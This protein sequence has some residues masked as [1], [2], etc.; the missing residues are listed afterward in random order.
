[1][2]PTFALFFSMAAAAQKPVQ[3]AKPAAHPSDQKTI[4]HPRLE[5]DPV[6]AQIIKMFRRAHSEDH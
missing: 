2:L 1:M 6:I 4:A 5:R 3:K